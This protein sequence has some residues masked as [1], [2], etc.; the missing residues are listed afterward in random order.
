MKV[1]ALAFAAAVVA[2][3]GCTSTTM[4]T[5]APKPQPIAPQQSTPLDRS[6]EEAQVRMRARVHTELAA[7]YYELRNM[8]IALDEIKLAMKADPE[9]GPAYNVAGLIYAELREE[10]LAQ[11]NFQRALRINPTDSDANNNYGQYLC[12]RKREGEA[13]KYFQAAIAN[14]LYGTPERAY[15]NA[16]LCTRRRGDV[17]TAEDF[18]LRAVRARPTQPQA[19]YQLADIA[20]A[21]KQYELAKQ[22][23]VRLEQ[24]TRPSAEV[25]WLALRVERRLGDR[26]AEAA[27]GRQLRREFPDSRETQALLG[28]LD[29]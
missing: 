5:P 27:F 1:R 22:Y 7:G 26:N 16:G 3:A 2:L 14:P 4:T 12:D 17:T 23:L 21:R 20:Y 28:G 8:A 19:L 9:Y 6:G 10:R 15:V 24:V 25:L 11:E 29:E 13:M 18:F